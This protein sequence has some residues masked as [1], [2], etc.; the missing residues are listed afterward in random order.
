MVFKDYNVT[1]NIH[2]NKVP[3]MIAMTDDGYKATS[4]AKYLSVY[5][6]M[7]K[8]SIVVPIDHLEM[9][10]PVLARAERIH[11]VYNAYPRKTNHRRNR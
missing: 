8:Y 5:I 2:S 4:E 6:P 1:I 11:A 3:C 7:T 9:Y 10:L